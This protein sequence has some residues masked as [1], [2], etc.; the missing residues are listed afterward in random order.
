MTLDEF[1]EKGRKESLREKKIYNDDDFMKCLEENEK[2]TKR[3]T[4]ISA[5]NR[6][7]HNITN[8]IN[9]S[10]ITKD[11]WEDFVGTLFGWSQYVMLKAKNRILASL[12]TSSAPPPP[13]KTRRQIYH[14]YL[15]SPE[16]SAVRGAKLEEA[17]YRCQVCNA[18]NLAG[19]KVLN[20]H[21]RT[22]E[23]IFH[24]LLTDLIVLCSDCHEI[25]HASGKL[26]K[27]EE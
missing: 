14:E 22:Y 3:D 15:M 9:E 18:Q 27:I 16:W 12:P 23:R 25:F 7:L 4:W 19:G 13:P 11:Q 17:E 1:V 10:D 20:V 21:H 5:I 24:E 6:D 26:A 2:F 8:Y